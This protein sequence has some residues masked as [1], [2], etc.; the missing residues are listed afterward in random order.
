M[1]SDK[2]YIINAYNQNMIN[3]LIADYTKAA[4]QAVCGM[5]YNKLNCEYSL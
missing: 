2:N 4:N 3:K 1:E 5:R